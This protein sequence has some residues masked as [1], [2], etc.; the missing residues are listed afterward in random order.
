[1]KVQRRVTIQIEVI[2]TSEGV[3][4]LLDSEGCELESTLVYFGGNQTSQLGQAAKN[5][6]LRSEYVT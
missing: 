5:A 2:S 3:L 6:I 1:M 4:T